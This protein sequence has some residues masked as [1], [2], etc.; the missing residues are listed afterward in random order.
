LTHQQAKLLIN[1]VVARCKKHH[2]TIATGT[3]M[4]VYSMSIIFKEVHSTKRSD[5]VNWRLILPDERGKYPSD[6][7]CNPLFKGQMR[8]HKLLS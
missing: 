3:V 4:N 7:D 8:V 2:Q 5:T 1:A 6:Y